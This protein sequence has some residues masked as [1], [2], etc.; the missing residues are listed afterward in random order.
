MANGEGDDVEGVGD[1]RQKHVTVVT[2]SGERREHGD[3]FLRHATDAWLVSAEQAFPPAATER[4]PKAE[5]RKVEVTQ[6]HAACFIT[7]ATAGSGATL[8]ALRGFRDDALASNPVGRG[9]VGLYYAVSPPVAATLER[10]PRS[11]TALAVR[12]LV[13]RCAELARARADATGALRRLVLTVALT[14][15]YAVGLLAAVAGHA[16]IR[17]RELA[18][19]R[20]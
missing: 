20:P 11:R 14:F 13:E 1:G 8:D 4:Y 19:R 9:L 3:V 5:L 16:C 17:C 2:R 10:H 6:H 12:R 7:T 15:L 18:A